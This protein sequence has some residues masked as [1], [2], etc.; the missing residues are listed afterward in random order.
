MLSQQI[1]KWLIFLF[2]LLNL[3]SRN[4]FETSI[5]DNFLLVSL[6]RKGMIITYVFYVC[7]TLYSF[8]TKGDGLLDILMEGDAFEKRLSELGVKIN[9][10]PS[11]LRR[12]GQGFCITFFLSCI[13]HRIL[14]VLKYDHWINWHWYEEPALGLLRLISLNFNLFSRDA[15][16]KEDFLFP[17][18]GLLAV[19]LE[20][21]VFNVWY[22]TEC[23][24]VLLTCLM[25][26]VFR[27]VRETFKTQSLNLDFKMIDLTPQLMRLH[28]HSMKLMDVINELYSTL[29]L[30]SVGFAFFYVCYWLNFTILEKSIRLHH[31]A[32]G[33]FLSKEITCVM[34]QADIHHIAH[35]ISKWFSVRYTEEQMSQDAAQKSRARDKCQEFNAFLLFL[36]QVNG[37]QDIGFKGYFFTITPAFV[38]GVRII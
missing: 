15:I 24:Q 29:V 5:G 28:F 30:L 6:I 25:W 21:I 13:I 35:D 18:I 32:F 11:H 17:I 22:F 36:S 4:L 14:N 9:Y 38:S 16:N 37:R 26:Y 27:K 8:Q 1:R 10:K 31:I 20:T 2:L 33:V 23:L 7:T 3:I 19:S 34:F 12:F